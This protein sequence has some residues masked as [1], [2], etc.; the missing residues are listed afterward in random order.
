MIKE[1]SEMTQSDI[2]P[3]FED[4]LYKF[5]VETSMKIYKVSQKGG[6]YLSDISKKLHVTYSDLKLDYYTGRDQSAPVVEWKSGVQKIK[7]GTKFKYI[8]MANNA[9]T[10]KWFKDFEGDGITLPD[11][12][13]INEPVRQ[14][15]DISIATVYY[16]PDFPVNYKMTIYDNETGQLMYER[17]FVGMS[18][19]RYI[20]EKVSS[21]GLTSGSY[22]CSI[23]LL[24][25][26]KIPYT[27]IF[28]L[29]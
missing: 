3:V 4:A 20:N 22:I 24:R 2:N 1:A 16:S 29:K 11:F 26:G 19:R 7:K 13:G 15:E 6:E 23:E 12:K 8:D 28:R 17:H 21:E 14:G 25:E 18:G 5:P 27:I 9:F 10:Y